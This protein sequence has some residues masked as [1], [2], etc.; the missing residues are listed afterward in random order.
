MRW[1]TKLAAAWAVESYYLENGMGALARSKDPNAVVLAAAAC[2]DRKMLAWLTSRYLGDED[3]L[4]ILRAIAANR[5]AGGAELTV[6]SWSA[7]LGVLIAVGGNPNTPEAALARLSRSRGIVA[8]AVAGNASTPSCSLE[9]MS[10][11]Q[12]E[13]TVLVTLIQNRN[14]SLEGAMRVAEKHPELYLTGVGEVGARLKAAGF[15]TIHADGQSILARAVLEEK[16]PWEEVAK[17]IE[18]EL[19]ELD[20]DQ[21]KLLKTLLSKTNSPVEELIKVVKEICKKHR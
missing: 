17:K 16:T 7:D 20:G 1:L 8:K 18:K 21:V 19:D 9:C 14:L 10:I 5:V 15:E 13:W 12:T 2:K 4:R 3:N 11:L 6:L